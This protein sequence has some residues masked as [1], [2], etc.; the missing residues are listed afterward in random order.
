MPRP[1]TERNE[2]GLVRRLERR[3]WQG[4]RQERL[5]RR[6]ARKRLAMHVFVHVQVRRFF[7]LNPYFRSFQFEHLVVNSPYSTVLYFKIN[8]PELSEF[9][10]VVCVYFNRMAFVE[11]NSC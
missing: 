10:T 1:E 7:Y 3:G 5:A 8:L 4:G 2:E 11:Y 9:L 6:L